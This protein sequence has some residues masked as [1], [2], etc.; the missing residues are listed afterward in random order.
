MTDAASERKRAAKHIV[1]TSHPTRN[2]AKPLAVDWGAAEPS[3]R[4]PIV[5][6]LTDRRRRNVIGAHAG[7]YALYRALAIAAGSL[8]PMHKPDLTDTAP[9][10]AIGPYPQWSEPGKIVSLDPFGHRVGEDFAAL[11]AAG[12]D[13]RPTIAV[14]RARLTVPELKEAIAAGRLAR[15]GRIL[16]ASGEVNVTKVAIEPVW[17]LPG[18]AARCGVPEQALRRSLFEE[19][20]GMF[21]ELV[22]R[23]DLKLFLPPIGSI[24]AYAF[25]DVAALADPSVPLACRVHDECNGSD[26]FGSDICTC[27]PYLVHG[28]EVCVETAQAGGVG[29]IVYNRKEG[30]GLGE[31]TK[32][33]V[34]NARKR[35]AGGDTADAYFLR[36]ECVAGVQDVRFQELMPDTLHWLGITRI[37]RFVSMSNMKYDAIVRQGIE[38]VERLE[39]PEDRIPPDAHVELT[40]K[41]AA[42][43]YTSRPAKPAAPSRAKGRGLT[44]Y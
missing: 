11:L 36:T 10:V 18:V 15:D 24:T 31:V 5:G 30:R 14:T 42:G 43:Y 29:L 23:P 22:T 40:A 25:G 41:K 4:G 33:L 34:Y 38:V 28:I 9:P 21:P 19:T 8:D 3:L 2:G 39:L 6:S 37:H 27:R 1:L 35:Q 16:L 7:S 13:I 32:F 12:W 17:Y 26:V 44:D 20:G